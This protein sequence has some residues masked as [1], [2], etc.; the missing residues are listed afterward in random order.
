VQR[1]DQLRTASSATPSWAS[2]ELVARTREVFEP[3]YG[4]ALSDDEIGEI[5]TNVGQ[6]FRIL[7]DAPS[8]H[9]ADRAASTKT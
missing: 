1:A 7:L 2:P 5:L 4:R 8:A 6:L 3:R 9:Q